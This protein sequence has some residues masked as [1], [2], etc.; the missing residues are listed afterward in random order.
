MRD[1]ERLSGAVADAG[2][3]AVA[4]GGTVRTGQ[5]LRVSGGLIAREDLRVLA[6]A[7]LEALIDL[8]AGE[9][10]RRRL[11]RWAR[12]EEV[13]YLQL[14]IGAAGDEDVLRR[15]AIGGGGPR[16]MIALYRTVIDGYGRELARAVERIAA[17][18]RPVAFGCAAGKDRTGILAAL[19]HSLLGVAEEDVVLAYTTMPPSPEAL[20]ARMQEE[21]D[22]PERFLRLPGARALLG[23][24]AEVMAATLA[25]VGDAEDY[26]L[27]HGLPE[28]A[29]ARLRER[30]VA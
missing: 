30:L 10:E 15:I 29:P 28:D 12:R 24:Q 3:L 14:G 27:Q 5:L 9:D 19:V 17:A 21:Y 16:G 8:R 11:V 1:V 13:E 22:V 2:G 6:D 26:L 18:E 25:Y 23:T 20:G 4:G 7:G